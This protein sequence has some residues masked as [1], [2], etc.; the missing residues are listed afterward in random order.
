MYQ[1]DDI[2]LA[3]TLI[4]VERAKVINVSG[5]RK[6][7]FLF[8]RDEESYKETILKY[9][10]RESLL[11]SPFDFVLSMRGL[12]GMIYGNGISRE[13]ETK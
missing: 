7:L 6:K 4:L 8:D 1:T 10:G 12:K 13:Q 9:Y 3:T 2:G 11:I 5:G